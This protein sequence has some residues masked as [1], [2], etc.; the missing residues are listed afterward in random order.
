MAF[1]PPSFFHSSLA[2]EKFIRSYFHLM[3]SGG[4]KTLRLLCLFFLTSFDVEP[5]SY[6]I[7]YQL[8]NAS[9]ELGWCLDLENIIGYLKN[10]WTKHRHVCTHFDAFSMLIPNMYIIFYTFKISENFRLSAT[11]TL[12]SFKYSQPK[13]V[14]SIML[15]ELYY[16]KNHTSCHEN[17]LSKCFVTIELVIKTWMW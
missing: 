2:I 13:Q 8:Q 11:W 1:P 14:K 12:K 4:C 9:D 16:Q 15:I 6:R 10:H 5:A 7:S 3:S 17:M